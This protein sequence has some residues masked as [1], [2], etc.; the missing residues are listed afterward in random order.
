MARAMKPV[1]QQL[2]LLRRGRE[3]GP[4]NGGAATGDTA[5]GGGVPLRMPGPGGRGHRAGMAGEGS[6]G[7]A[8]QHTRRG[9]EECV[10]GRGV[11]RPVSR[12]ETEM[13]EHA[14]MRQQRNG[15]ETDG[16]REQ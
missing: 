8:R 13:V 9:H 7:P 3:W 15:V 12:L 2:K 5:Q 1:K 10:L 14:W 4:G 11:D 16:L 6:A